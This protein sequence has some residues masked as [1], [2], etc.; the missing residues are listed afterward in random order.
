MDSNF[1]EKEREL[2]SKKGIRADKLL[3]ILKKTNAYG[4]EKFNSL[5]NF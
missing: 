3:P 4:F 2:V 5:V 1:N